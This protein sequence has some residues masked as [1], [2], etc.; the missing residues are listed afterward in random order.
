VKSNT[1][2]T[3]RLWNSPE[4]NQKWL[5]M[6]TPPHASDVVADKPCPQ[7]FGS[8]EISRSQLVEQPCLQPP[9]PGKCEQPKCPVSELVNTVAEYG[10]RP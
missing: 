6:W 9:A 8:L 3:L 2:Y 10:A 1:L 7:S 4:M 5:L